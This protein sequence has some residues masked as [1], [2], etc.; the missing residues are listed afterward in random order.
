MNRE[1]AFGI[2]MESLDLAQDLSGHA[3]LRNPDWLKPELTYEEVVE[4][5]KTSQTAFVK[6][7]GQAYDLYIKINEWAKEYPLEE[8]K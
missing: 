6:A 4:E 3:M 7:T 8:K 2:V 5:L 1:Q